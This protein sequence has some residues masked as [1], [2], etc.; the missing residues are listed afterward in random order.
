MALCGKKT[1][2]GCRLTYGMH[3]FE[4]HAQPLVCDM[5]SVKGGNARPITGFHDAVRRVYDASRN[6]VRRPG[7]QC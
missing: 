1:V 6:A 2:R 4:Q 3:A 7:R 5:C